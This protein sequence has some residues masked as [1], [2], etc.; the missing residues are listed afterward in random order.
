LPWPP[1]ASYSVLA[2][3]IHVDTKKMIKLLQGDCLERMKEIPDGSVDMILADPP[4]GTTACKWDSIIPLEPMWEQLK[5][6]IKPS[7]AI[8]LTAGQPFTSALITSNLPMF[9][10]CWTWEKSRVSGFTN[11]KNKPLNTVEDI[12]VFSKGVCANGGKIM[13]EYNPQGLKRI[14]KKM[15]G[16]R[17][18]GDE[19]QLH[20]SNNEKDY[21]Q[22][23]TNY[24]KNI[25]KI[26]SE[27]KGVHPTQKPVALMDYL[28]KTYTNEGEIVLD[29]TMGSGST[30]VAAKRLNR[31]FIGVEL[32]EGYFKIAQERINDQ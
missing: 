13:M 7:G 31:S 19:H 12:A 22:E 15:N 8:V 28:I 9:K 14:D 4:Y 29:F 1:A 18:R 26:Q 10:Y 3:L 25:L 5:R 11:A 23:F 20:R 24:P 21:V 27:G 30:G 17:K 16:T 6:V 32:D 2:I